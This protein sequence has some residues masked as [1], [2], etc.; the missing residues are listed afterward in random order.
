MKSLD[1]KYL[2]NKDG[3]KTKAFCYY[4][5]DMDKNALYSYIILLFILL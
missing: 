1:A 4:N 5:L 2:L 3:K